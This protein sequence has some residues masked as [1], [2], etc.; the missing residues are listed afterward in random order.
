[1]RSEHTKLLSTACVLL[2]SADGHTI[3]ARVALDSYSEECFVAEHVVEALSLPQSATHVVVNFSLQ[4]SALTLKKLTSLLPRSQVSIDKWSH[5]D[6][7]QLAEP[8]CGVPGRIDCI[9]N[10]E[11][12]AAV[13]R[14]GLIAGPHGTPTALS[15]ALGWILMGAARES[16]ANDS[17]CTRTFQLSIDYD[18]TDMLRRF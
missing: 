18:L 10:T 3:T 11:I 14:P 2:Q 12:F 5:L 9:L 6:G 16:V 1:M 7:T 13:L 4:F 8:H 17:T 15:T